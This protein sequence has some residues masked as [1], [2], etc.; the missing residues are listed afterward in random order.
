MSHERPQPPATPNPDDEFGLTRQEQ[1]YNRVNDERF[2]AFLD[3]ELTTIHRVETS[4][5]NYGQFLFVTLSRMAG[6][7]RRL[8]SFYGLGEH[9]LRERWI[10]S[11]WCYYRA[12][13]FQDVIE[14][15][16]DRQEAQ[17]LIQQR[18]EEIAPYVHQRPQSGRGKLFELLADLADDDGASAEMDDLGDFADW[19]GDG[20]E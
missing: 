1:L 3:D 7:Q 20:L 16:L 2:Q 11:E 5:N 6:D 10:V 14:Q 17:D 19:L 12:H 4:S 15:Q 13:P 9:E 18:R 8:I